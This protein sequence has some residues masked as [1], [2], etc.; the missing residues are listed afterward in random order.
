V[1]VLQAVVER[2]ERLTWGDESLPCHVVVYRADSGSGVSEGETRGRMW[3]DA[4][5]LVLRQEISILGSNLHFVR[6]K[7]D[8]AHDVYAA[9]GNDWFGELSSRVAK[10]LLAE[11]I[12]TGL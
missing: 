10:R 6:L 11:L 7:G 5:G 1:E 4:E 3:V 8:V 9:L 2:Q 12:T